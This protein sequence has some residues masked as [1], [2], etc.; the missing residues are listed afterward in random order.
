LSFEIIEN[1]VLLYKNHAAIETSKIAGICALSEAVIP[2]WGSVYFPRGPGRGDS[3]PENNEKQGGKV[4]ES[5][6]FNA[7][8]GHW[9]LHGKRVKKLKAQS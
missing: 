5:V 4:K 3:F 7:I 8:Y 1:T 6:Q 2:H 9:I